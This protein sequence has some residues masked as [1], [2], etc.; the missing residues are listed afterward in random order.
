MLDRNLMTF[1]IWAKAGPRDTPKDAK[2]GP[3]DSHDPRMANAASDP[4]HF[5]DSSEN[6]V[7]LLTHSNAFH[8]GNEKVLMKDD[9][10]D[11]YDGM[12]HRKSEYYGKGV[13]FYT[14]ERTIVGI[15][16]FNLFNRLP[17]ARQIITDKKSVDEIDELVELFNIH[18]S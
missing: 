11:H 12:P 5:K 9:S 7:D 10:A 14:K 2:A 8:Q 15:L 13:V 1:S 6:S 17:L 3:G 16:L 18:D 4:L